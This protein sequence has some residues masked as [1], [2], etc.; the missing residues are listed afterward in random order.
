MIKSLKISGYKS[1]VNLEIIFGSLTLLAGLNNSGKSSVIQ[2]LRMYSA[3]YNGKSP[4]L[5]GHG[6]VAELRSDFVN[7]SDDICVTANFSDQSTENMR[8]STNS[9]YRPSICPE[10]FY[11][12][13]DRLGP[14]P[15]LPIN[16]SLDS[17]LRVGDRGEFV[18]DFVKKLEDYG[19]LLPDQLVHPSSEG[20]TFEYV[21]QG[22]LSEIAPG[23]NFSFTTNKKA[24]ISQAEINNYRPANVGFGLSY[25]LP[26]IAATLG[27]AAK[28]PTFTTQDEWLNN[29]ETL[30]S[31]H[32]VLVVL[33]NPEAH[34]HPQ[35]Q[36]AM[37]KLIAIA[38]SCGVQIVVETHSEHVMDGIRIAV[39]SELIKSELVKFHYLSKNK[40]GVTQIDTPNLD[41]DGKVD[42][43]PEGFFDQTLK[44]RSILAK[45]KR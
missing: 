42:F 18:F 1:I 20:K 2:A 8:L 14:Q 29:W 10:F 23:V 5:E 24:D 30:K 31:Q 36:T 37:G 33:E 38:A 17:K 45:R 25:T 35:G 44:N 15:Y 13:A 32:G 39:K 28:V 43:W 3:A 16:I 12:G 41:D 11:V 21:L 6:D 40:D 9:I 26:I 4:L 27:A 22:W 19:Y 34:L 7:L